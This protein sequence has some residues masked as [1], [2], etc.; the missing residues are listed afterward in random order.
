MIIITESI[1]IRFNSAFRAYR[2]DVLRPFP[3]FLLKWREGF[4]CVRNKRS[5]PLVKCSS[6]ICLA[7]S[8]VK[9]VVFLQNLTW[10]ESQV[11]FLW[12]WGTVSDLKIILMYLFTF[13]CFWRSLHTHIWFSM[14]GHFNLKTL[15]H[16]LANTLRCSSYFKETHERRSLN[17][18]FLAV[19][20]PAR[21]SSPP[22]EAADKWLTENH[23]GLSFWGD[24]SGAPEMLLQCHSVSCLFLNYPLNLRIPFN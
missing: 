17:L 1:Y 19:N 11:N 9:E 23:S 3:R 20:N 7:F 10:P 6:E 22:L 2:L 4:P 8:M 18:L 12:L 24:R 13:S 15:I 5:G 14:K 16:G 21:V